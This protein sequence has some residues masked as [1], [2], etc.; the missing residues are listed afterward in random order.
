[1]PDFAA[2]Q[3][4]VTVVMPVRNE[5]V[6]IA[7]SLNAVLN[8]EYPSERIE[9]IIADGMSTDG[10]V[11]AIF[12]VVGAERVQIIRNER[13]LQAAGLNCAIR[14]ARGEIVIRVD[15]HTIIAPDYVQRCVDLLQETGADGVGGSLN[16][17]GHTPMG[18]AIAAA[19]KSRFAIPS[20]F[21]VSKKAQ[22]AETVY[23]G[24]WRRCIF[25]RIG[26]FDERLVVNEDY[27]LNYRIHKVG[28]S[29]YYSPELRS[30][31]HGQQRLSE[32]MRR[33]FQYGYG[34]PRTLMK[35]PASLRLRQIAAPS[36]VGF[37]VGVPLLACFCAEL[38]T[39]WAG[40]VL[41]YL[42]A[43]GLFS[44]WT[45]WHNRA[46]VIWLLPL[47]FVTIHIAWGSG[48]WL[49]MLRVLLD[50]LPQFE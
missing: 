42:I 38:G 34:K 30:E 3:P 2:H 18:Q 16:P 26:L 49:G 25:D 45:A 40:G 10:T 1:M 22:Y 28:G 39:I 36:L 5:A 6:W 20:I 27:E 46:R 14:Q 32:L 48:F 50:R 8:Q 33:Y 24:A 11:E 12:N 41:T 15:G 43:N 31:Y 44:L 37:L 23:M 29:L 9:I 19:S 4:L 47:V 7:H 35:H 21:R 17:V 13:R